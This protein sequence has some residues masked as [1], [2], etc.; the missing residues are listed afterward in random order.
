MTYWAFKT[1][2][3]E[4]GDRMSW[5]PY[6]D[7]AVCPLFSKQCVCWVRSLWPTAAVLIV[8]LCLQYCAGTPAH[9]PM[10]HTH[11]HTHRSV[12]PPQ[13]ASRH[14]SWPQLLKCQGSQVAFQQMDSLSVCACVCV[15]VCRGLV[16]A[17]C[18]CVLTWLCRYNN[19]N[20][21]E[22]RESGA[23]LACA[24]VTIGQRSARMTKASDSTEVTRPGLRFGYSQLFFLLLGYQWPGICGAIPDGLTRVLS[25][26]SEVTAN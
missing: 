4:R 25:K 16:R 17:D 8:L 13:L 24:G 5:L 15:C 21:E 22:G 1:V 7:P 12:E 9:L 19:H 6:C 14:V 26:M 20:L 18:W 23:G 11:T 10:S 2:E 3:Q